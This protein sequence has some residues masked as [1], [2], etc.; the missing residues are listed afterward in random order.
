[1]TSTIQTDRERCAAPELPGEESDTTME[2]QEYETVSIIA[3]AAKIERWE[4]EQRAGPLGR[5]NLQLGSL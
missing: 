5:W 2:G 3:G 4:N 1:M